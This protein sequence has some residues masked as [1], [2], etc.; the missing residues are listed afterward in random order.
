MSK[1]LSANIHDPN[2]TADE[3]DLYFNGEMIESGG[4][5]LVYAPSVA[6]TK[7]DN[8]TLT[9]RFNRAIPENAVIISD[10]NIT[11]SGAGGAVIGGYNSIQNVLLRYDAGS[12]TNIGTLG[13]TALIWSEDRRECTLALVTGSSAPFKFYYAASNY[14]FIAIYIE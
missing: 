5:G 14:K 6:V 8:Y 4:S 13:T 1:A 3:Y 11:L 9:I 7:V 12:E 10:A 2:H